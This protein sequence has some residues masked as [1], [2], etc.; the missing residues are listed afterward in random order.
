M[1][2]SHTQPV[3][4][5][6]KVGAYWIVSPVSD[7]VAHVITETQNALKK[8]FSDSVWTVPRD[9]L[10]ISF[11]ALS[12]FFEFTS[13]S[14]PPADISD[15]YTDVFG[16]LLANHPPIRL[17]FDTI[18]AFPAA[19]ILKAK[20]DGSYQSLRNQFNS[21]VELPTGTKATPDIIHTTICKFH[22]AID[23]DEVKGFLSTQNIDIE[24]VVS[25]FRIV[26]EK[27]LY[28]IDYDVLERFTLNST[29][30]GYSSS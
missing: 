24:M 17:R 18:E 15:T 21:S 10:H 6:Q 1:S 7:E 26:R 25:E 9:S 14:N 11:N 27:I 19:I 22:K 28:M 4:T 5:N 8:R 12:P 23:L 20:D 3:D 13:T 29:N 16:K 30:S 2:D